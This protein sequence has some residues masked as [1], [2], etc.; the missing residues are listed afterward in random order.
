M[1]GCLLSPRACVPG[2]LQFCAV[3]LRQEKLPR[4]QRFITP[5]RAPCGLPCCASVAPFAGKLF[6]FFFF[7]LFLF[8][9]WQ[10]TCSDRQRAAARRPRFFGRYLL[11]ALDAAFS[12]PC[13]ESALGR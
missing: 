5:V 13:S 12:S 10:W 2:L 9:K 1:K 3:L 11:R 8:S 4:H 6:F 7:F